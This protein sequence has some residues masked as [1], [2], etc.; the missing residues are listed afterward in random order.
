MKGRFILI[1]FGVDLDKSADDLKEHTKEH[2]IDEEQRARM[3]VGLA[4]DLLRWEMPEDFAWVPEHTVYGDIRPEIDDLLDPYGE[5]VKVGEGE[6][7]WTTGWPNYP[8]IERDTSNG[9][10]PF[11]KPEAV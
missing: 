5:N 4:I 6:H 1:P 8:L 9:E 2:G 10:S 3:L 11:M 7:T